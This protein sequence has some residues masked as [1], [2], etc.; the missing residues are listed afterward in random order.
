[1][2]AGAVF[3]GLG[4][5]TGAIVF[6]LLARRRGLRADHTVLLAVVTFVCGIVGAKVTQAF[7][8][9]AAPTALDPSAGGRALLG[10]ILAGWIGFEAVKAKLGLKSSLGDAVAPALAAGEAV[11]RIGCFLNPCCLGGPFDGPWSVHQGGCDRHPAQ[12]YS[13][14]FA[15]AL[16]IG[17]LAVRNRTPYP[18]A[19]F[20]VYLAVWGLGRFGQE[21]FR[22]RDH[23]LGPF[24][25]MQLAS[26]QT[27]LAGAAFLIV[28]TVRRRR[29]L[30]PVE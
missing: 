2:T 4:Y 14:A 13:A 23:L 8:Q 27:A 30:E 25:A 22:D 11:G 12:L 20:H 3:T 15:A 16:T 1:M 6:W 18:G 26:L 19:S 21:F 9:G 7:V 28:H 10:G 17:L 5:A 24:G 29:S